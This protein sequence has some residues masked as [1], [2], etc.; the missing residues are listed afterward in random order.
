MS[1]KRRVLFLAPFPPRLDA[2][3]GGGRT[4]ARTI[5]ELASRHHV[6]LVTLRLPDEPQ[7]DEAVRARCELVKEVARPLVGS[8][9]TRLWSERQRLRL[10][11]SDAPDWV[12]GCSVSDYE[13]QLRDVLH[14]WKPEVVQIEFA[15]MGQYARV[16]SASHARPILVEHDPSGD[17][18]IRSWAKYRASIMRRVDAVVVFTRRD[19]EA[20]ASL[21]PDSRF[22]RIPISADV[23]SSE[24]DPLGRHPASLLFVGSYDHPPN[25]E[26][27]RR[28]A[29]DIF[30]RLVEHYPDLKL[31]LVGESPPGDLAGPGVATPGRVADVNPYLDEAAI[32]V[33][34][35]HSGGGMR[36]KVLEALAA[37]KAVVASKLAIEGIDV[38]HGEHVL[39][40]D[41]DQEFT[42]AVLSLLDDPQRRAALAAGARAWALAN[43]G[44][45]RAVG[46]Y[47]SL[48][49][50][51]LTSGAKT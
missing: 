49:D 14:G 24:L 28:L 21:A 19:Q 17:G 18:E 13:Q 3:H 37:G 5:F 39:V 2:P 31:Q 30:P 32:V 36:V 8:S 34:P 6:A 38:V 46:A 43:L 26:A 22:V 11:L 12:I 48:Y 27:A 47:E 15:V 50:S 7:V 9:P 45:E 16:V 42:A 25:V 23:P 51:L 1:E 4:L 44:W 33:A 20:L 41:S 35:I 10:M 40:A 29:G